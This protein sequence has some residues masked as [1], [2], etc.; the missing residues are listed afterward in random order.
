MAGE[1]ML[2]ASGEIKVMVLMRASRPHFL[3]CEKFC[4]F[5][6]S[7]CPS[8]PTIPWARSVS[9]KHVPTGLGEVVVFS[10]S[11]AALVS[12]C[13]D[14]WYFSG[15]PIMIGVIAYVNLVV[16]VVR[17]GME[18]S[19]RGIGAL[20]RQSKINQNWTMPKIFQCHGT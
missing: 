19:G 3:P 2:E 6:G 10:R 15:S 14:D 16:V 1:N 8:Q 17:N 13:G 7:S 11:G 18:A 5:A 20:Y 4:G 9:G 12:A